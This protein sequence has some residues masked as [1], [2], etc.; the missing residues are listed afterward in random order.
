MG[1]LE[2]RVAYVTGGASGIGEATVRRFAAEGARVV[3]GDLQADRG[4]ALAGELGD[5]V[6]FA[7]VDVRAEDD[8]AAAV[9]LAVERFGRL[10]I[11]FANAG[12]VGVTGPLA[13]TPLDEWRFTID[14]L[15]TGVFVT[16]K[17]AA[18]VLGD[19][20]NLLATASIAGVQGGLG[21]HAYT[22]AKHGVVGLVRAAA[23][24]LTPRGIRVNAIA[25][26]GMATP[27]VA[28]MALG[29]KDDVE[30]MRKALSATSPTGRGGTAEDV[31][32]AALYLVADSG[33]MISGHTLVLDLARTTGEYGGQFL[34]RQQMLREAGL[35][36]LS[37]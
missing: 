20:G 16:F 8:Q 5:G 18:R 23:S 25:P 7:R 10:D 3:I 22:A 31:A 9:D 27:M 28:A 29:D 11:A 14:V 6:A 26:T 21:P 35:Q 12:I 2:G 37:S 36:G 19:G 13:E 17:Q 30:G 33:A 15:L 32:E 1:S 34:E 4:E 24:E